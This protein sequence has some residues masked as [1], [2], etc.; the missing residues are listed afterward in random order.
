MAK[1]APC[2]HCG[3]R[4]ALDKRG[5]VKAHGPANPFV[6]ANVYCPGTG[7][8]PRREDRPA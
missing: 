2:P 4:T 5:R 8:A 6:A 1:R 7:K 3:R